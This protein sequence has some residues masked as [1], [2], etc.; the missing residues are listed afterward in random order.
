MLTITR[1]LDC[2]AVA[3]RIVKTDIPVHCRGCG[4]AN[5]SW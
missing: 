1:C 2:G 3:S 5:L 4:S